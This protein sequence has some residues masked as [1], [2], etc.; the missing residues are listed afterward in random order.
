MTLA[1]DDNNSITAD[2][3]NRAQCELGDHQGGRLGGGIGAARNI[4]AGEL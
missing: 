3:A 2:Y 1:D 4:G